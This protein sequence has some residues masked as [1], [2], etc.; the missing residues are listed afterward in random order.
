[1]K[2]YSSWEERKMQQQTRHM[3]YTQVRKISNDSSQK[4][5][6]SVEEK[7]YAATFKTHEE[8][9]DP[10][11]IQRFCLTKSSSAQDI[12]EIKPEMTQTQKTQMPRQG[13]T[14][15]TCKAGTT[16]AEV[17]YHDGLYAEQQRS[18]T[19]MDHTQSSRGHI[20]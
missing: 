16:P 2:S 10:E 4:K 6:I 1:M 9:S 7:E 11:G 8:N 13:H 20:P 5:I 3:S 12:E 17:T 15:Q 19:M 14:A 18:H